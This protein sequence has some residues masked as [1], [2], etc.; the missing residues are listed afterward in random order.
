M[1]TIPVHGVLSLTFFLH[2][3]CSDRLGSKKAGWIDG[4]L[5]A[6]QVPSNLH[7]SLDKVRQHGD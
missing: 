3:S 2:S 4:W 7:I 1:A 6:I 5:H